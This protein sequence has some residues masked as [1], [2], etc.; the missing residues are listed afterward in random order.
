MLAHDIKKTLEFLIHYEDVEIT[1]T[2]GGFVLSYSKLTREFL[3]ED[4]VAGFTDKFKNISSCTIAL[5]K[6]IV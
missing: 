6:I 2:F 5:N 4:T 3:I 1:H